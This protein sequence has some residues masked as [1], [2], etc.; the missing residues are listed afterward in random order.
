VQAEVE[1]TNEKTIEEEAGSVIP[2][3]IGVVVALIVIIIVLAVLFSRS[4][5][6][7]INSVQ[8]EKRVNAE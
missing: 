3:V 4:K 2:I 5:K 1:T 6:P 7:D 8:D